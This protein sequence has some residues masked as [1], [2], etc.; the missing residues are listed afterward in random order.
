[1]MDR[2]THFVLEVPN[3]K[4]AQLDRLSLPDALIGPLTA[5]AVFARAVGEFVDAQGAPLK[6]KSKF[7][8]FSVRVPGSPAQY[9]WARHIA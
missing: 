7:P 1:M 8:V 3:D 6:E 2:P 5:N 4:G 9:V